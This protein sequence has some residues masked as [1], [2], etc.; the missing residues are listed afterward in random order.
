M[1]SFLGGIV[2]SIE[3]AIGGI[4]WGVEVIKTSLYALLYAISCLLLMLLDFIQSIFRKLAGLDTYYYEG[5]SDGFEHEDILQRLL[6]TPE[7][8]KAFG[9][10]IVVGIILLFIFTIIQFIRIEYTT[11]GAKNSKGNIIKQSLKSLAMFVIIPLGSLVGIFLSNKILQILDNATKG[12]D[13][14]IGGQIFKVCAY[15][16][17][18]IRAGESKYVQAGPIG[19]AIQSVRYLSKYDA[20]NEAK[21]ETDD[22]KITV[23]KFKRSA[24]DLI[25]GLTTLVK[26]Q[27]VP[28]GQTEKNYEG[29]DVDAYKI[30]SYE[31]SIS[32]SGDLTLT[33]VN[34]DPTAI[35]PEYLK[36]K[37]GLDLAAAIDDLFSLSG[38]D[39]V[40]SKTDIG[41]IGSINSGDDLIS[42]VSLSPLTRIRE[43]SKINYTNIRAVRYFYNM[44]D[45]SFVLLWVLAIFSIICLYKAAF[46]MVMRIYMCCVLFIISPPII[47][48][49]PLDNGKALG[50]WKNQ[51]IGQVLAGYGT[52]VGMNIFLTILPII[53]KIELFGGNEGF[54]GMADNFFNGLTQAI[55]IL[56]GCYMLKDI[57]K[58]ISG[59]IG[60]KDAMESGEGMGKQVAAGAAKVGAIGLAVGGAAIGAGA[61]MASGI[62]GK[63]STKKSFAADKAAGEAEKAIADTA[64]AQKTFD[65]VKDDKGF[66]TAAKDAMAKDLMN[67]KSYNDLSA[68]E[69]K[70]LDNLYA[71]ADDAYMQDLAGNMGSEGKKYTNAKNNLDSAKANE[72]AKVEDAKSKVYEASVEEQD[73]KMAKLRSFSK[74]TGLVGAR[75]QTGAL[76]NVTNIAANTGTGKF[77]KGV[78]GDMAPELVGGKGFSAYD[79]EIAGQSDAYAQLIGQMGKEKAKKANEKDAMKG[80]SRAA[81]TDNRA[82]IAQ[83]AA[84]QAYKE[85]VGADKMQ[86]A[87][88]AG[89]KQALQEIGNSLNAGTMTKDEAVKQVN[90]KV[91]EMRTS[92]NYSNDAIERAE[93]G[94]RDFASSGNATTLQAM[95][96]DKQTFETK[97]D[98]AMKDPNIQ[99]ELQKMQRDLAAGKHAIAVQSAQELKKMLSGRGIEIAGIDEIM[100]ALEKQARDDKASEKDIKKTLEA[101]TKQLG[102]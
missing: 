57:S 11:E 24:K 82:K 73:E 78:M 49:S 7:V 17:N 99:S 21:I 81:D 54:W 22:F 66:K 10:L 47:A 19:N 75:L 35:A 15:D 93:K 43:G 9:A 14:T 72:E 13:A 63:I 95:I 6:T 4:L 87:V 48:M 16:A 25:Y 36:G 89:T 40:K 101:L 56:V 88:A 100:Q 33:V 79:K 12:S 85:I 42:I 1:V 26:L 83:D 18:P 92:G 51:F 31:Q 23:D 91:N 5:V 37:T 77:V 84:G 61:K 59:L 27:V 96:N 53:K 34:I 97:M 45:F 29:E 69:K 94:A 76:H 41:K 32:F 64:K 60:A 20:Y 52:V 68:D 65:A 3:L 80:W 86:K 55:F 98:I 38:K 58:T 62:A 70:T 74:K 44:Q 39:V 8:L 50:N 28:S 71:N 46:G 2:E 90:A 102:K 67:G 30:F